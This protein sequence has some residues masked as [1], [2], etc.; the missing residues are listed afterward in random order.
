MVS[1]ILYLHGF[2]SA[3]NPN[4][5]KV[6]ALES[7]GKVV[8]IAP[9]YTKG[10]H[11]VFDEVYSFA[12]H[13]KVNLIV[14][15]SMGAYFSSRLGQVMELPHVMINPS[16]T[17]SKTLTAYIGK[18]IDH[19]GNEY[20]LS[21]NIVAHWPDMTVSERGLMILDMGDEI[22][23]SKETYEKFKNICEVVTYEGGSHRFDHIKE[24]IGIIENYFLLSTVSSGFGIN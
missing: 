12:V 8:A 19:Y 14:G 18:N 7:I 20:C 22:L 4:S 21:E 13:H 3:V 10:V 16:H 17:P 9:D 15:T 1:K 24:A 2:G 6:K 5:E 23:N 11:V